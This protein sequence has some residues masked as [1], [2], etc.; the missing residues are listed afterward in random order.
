MITFAQARDFLLKHREDYE[1]ARAG[2]RWPDPV[3]FNWAIDWFDKQL[4]SDPGTRDR[5]ALWIVDLAA[6][7]EI[8]VTFAELSRQSN[9]AANWL[10]AIGVTRGD[11]ILLALGNVVALWEIMLAAMKL[12]A[13]VIPA[14][15]LLPP[16]ELAERN[17]RAGTR[18]VITSADQTS[19]FVAEPGIRRIVVGAQQ[20]IPE[21]DRYDPRSAM[22]TFAVIGQTQPDDPLLLY[23]TSGTTAKPK[24][25][26][27]THRSYPVGHLSTMYALG[28]SQVTFT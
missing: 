23:F 14:T 18:F 28:S 9:E 12:G 3:P 7:T 26:R 24:L 13:V 8:K 19:K 10:R 4:A 6:K 22:P 11:R 2:F 17:R 16:A 27:H 25:V 5:L 15:T 21:W 20:A 1:R